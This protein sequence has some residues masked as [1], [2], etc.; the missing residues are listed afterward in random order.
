MRRAAAT[1]ASTGARARAGE[2][3]AR[4]PRRRRV[5]AGRARA[6][7][8]GS[9]NALPRTPASGI[10]TCTR[11]TTRPPSTTGK[12]SRRTGPGVTP[13]AVSVSKVSRPS[14]ALRR[15]SALSGSSVW[16]ARARRGSGRPSGSSSWRNRSREGWTE[17]R[18]ELASSLRPAPICRL[19][20][21]TACATET[22]EA[23]TFVCS[24][25]SSSRRAAIPSSVRR[26]P[27]AAVYQSVRRQ[28]RLAGR[29]ARLTARAPSTRSRRRARCAAASARSRRR[30]SAGD[31]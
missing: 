11:C 7:S 9:A 15:A 14:A 22:S 10:A 25:R 3:P 24:V 18:V 31:S 23:S 28:R 5:R 4:R 30:S 1:M 26:P 29:R 6:G 2:D 20:A 27:S 19:D 17:K 12:V 8:A 21:A 16:V 13:G